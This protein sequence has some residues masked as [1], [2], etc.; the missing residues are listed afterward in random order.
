MATSGSFN[1]NSVGSFYFTFSWSRTGTNATANQHTIYYELVAHNSPGSYRTVYLKDLYVNGSQVFYHG[2]NSS[3]GVKYYDGNIV[4]SGT[5]TINSY[6]SAGNG[7]FSASFTAGVGQWPSSNCSG[8]GSWEL[9]KIPRYTSITTHSVGS[10]TMNSF[11]VTWA[12]ADKCSNVYY[13]LNGGSWNQVATNVSSGNY[14]ISG[15]TAGT[16]YNVRTRVLRA[17]S[18]LETISGYLYPTTCSKATLS[19]IGTVTL[20]IPNETNTASL[21]YTITNNS[22]KTATVY[23]EKNSGGNNYGTSATVNSGA[24]GAKTITIPASTVKT[25]YTENTT[26]KE[27]STMQL[28]A[29]VTEGSNNYYDRKAVTIKFSEANA[30]PTAI[31]TANC[32]YLDTN[33]NARALTGSSSTAVTSGLK[34]IPGYSNV[35]ITV[36]K[37]PLTLRANSGATQKDVSIGGRTAKAST[38]DVT[39]TFSKATATAYSIVATDSRGYSKSHT[40][41]VT[42][43][44]YNALTI[45]TFEATRDSSDNTKG[46]YK[47][48]GTYQ[49]S[50]YGGSTTNTV[51]SVTVTCSGITIGAATISNNS[52]NWTATGSLSGLTVGTSYTLQASVGDYAGGKLGIAKSTSSTT[53]N[54]GQFLMTAMKGKGV[55]FGG[56]YDTSLGGPLQIGKREVLGSTLIKKWS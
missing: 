47:L 17:D 56:L 33:A 16:G 12:A 41:N 9:D 10:I 31:A 23:L 15:L 4:A 51:N 38:A 42:S 48:T 11:K 24:G 5:A 34:I 13:S 32:K 52:G 35:Q 27:F 50:N 44:P 21:S 20:P 36:T 25:L 45:L 22:S 29:K 39:E 40:M 28:T 2:G 37:N 54:S 1:T 3:S 55:C 18:G 49:N 30:G 6:N 53:V 26:V 14:T 7:S 46:T 8:S 19:N 43:Y